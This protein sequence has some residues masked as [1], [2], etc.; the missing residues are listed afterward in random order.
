MRDSLAWR[1]AENLQLWRPGSFSHMPLLHMHTHAHIPHSGWC[2]RREDFHLKVFLAKEKDSIQTLS[3]STR[4]EQI[5]RK[6]PSIHPIHSPPLHYRGTF[7]KT[8]LVKSKP[9]QTGRRNTCEHWEEVSN[10]LILSESYIESATWLA[11][12]TECPSP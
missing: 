1:K 7:P 11:H 4:A 10:Y 8:S 6:H 2:C 9:T 5:N 3:S 12:M